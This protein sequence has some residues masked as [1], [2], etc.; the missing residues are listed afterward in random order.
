MKTRT[1][2]PVFLDNG[3]PVND[4]ALGGTKLYKHTIE[5]IDQE[6]QNWLHLIMISTNPI[7]INDNE[8][9]LVSSDGY[10]SIPYFYDEDEG[11]YGVVYKFV[12]DSGTIQVDAYDYVNEVNINKTFNREDNI[13]IHDTVT[14]L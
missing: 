14:P 10:I 8:Y 13:Q 11:G 3:Q 5:L 12:A 4:S 6:N 2:Q 7:G 9:G 1:N